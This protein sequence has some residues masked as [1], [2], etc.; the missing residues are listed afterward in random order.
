MAA[1][2][3]NLY[4]FRPSGCVGRPLLDD[5]SIFSM[6]SSL[7]WASVSNFLRR[8]LS[9]LS[10]FNCRVSC[11]IRSFAVL[12]AFGLQASYVRLEG[13]LAFDLLQL[14]ERESAFR[15]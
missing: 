5:R 8:A 4:G 2:I 13:L 1:N 14:Q 12:S 9:S 11:A 10:A 7:A 15:R 6:A 3:G